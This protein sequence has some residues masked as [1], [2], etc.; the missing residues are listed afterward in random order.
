MEITGKNE[1]MIKNA[2]D[3]KITKYQNVLKTLKKIPKK[4]TWKNFKTNLEKHIKNCL[5]YIIKKHD[6]S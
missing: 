3:F 5:I 2:H 6:R 1:S 4:P